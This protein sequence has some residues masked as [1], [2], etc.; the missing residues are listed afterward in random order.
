MKLSE[1]INEYLERKRSDGLAFADGETWLRKLAAREGDIC[2]DSLSALNI[3]RFL[4]TCSK[5]PHAWQTKCRFLLRFFDYWVARGMMM[6]VLIPLIRPKTIKSFLPYVFREWEVRRLLSSAIQFETH[7]VESKTLRILTLMCFA[8]GAAP[9]ELR[10]LKRRDVHLTKRSILL[11]NARSG[12]R[13]I[14]ISTELRDI[15]INY[16]TWRFASGSTSEYLFVTKEKLM[17]N[18][19]QLGKCFARLCIYAGVKRSDGY[20]RSPRIQ[21]FRTTFA[22]H[23][24]GAWMKDGADLNKMLPAL[25]AYMGRRNLLSGQEYFRMTPERFR[26]QLDSISPVKG[27]KYWREDATLTNPLAMG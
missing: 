4:D 22:V 5:S 23:R 18:Q 24:I 26:K 12:A 14:P 7:V 20:T 19:T 6:P 2:L 21:D 3:M 27:K 10:R 1:A 8:T 25:A 11:E 13:T 16:M 17:L 15:L 9:G